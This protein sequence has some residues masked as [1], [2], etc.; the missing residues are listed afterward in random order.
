MSRVAVLI[1]GDYMRFTLHNRLDRFPAL[2]DFRA[3]RSNLMAAYRAAANNVELE[4]PASASADTSCLYRIFY[5]TADPYGGPPFTG[6]AQQSYEF[7]KQ[8]ERE[9]DVAVRRGAVK[10]RGWKVKSSIVHK[11]ING[12]TVQLDKSGIKRNYVQKGVDMRI[13]LDIATLALKRLVNDVVVVT[14]DLDMVPAFKL[15]RTEGLRVYVDT[16]GGM[17]AE[18]KLQVH[19]DRVIG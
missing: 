8:L 17:D 16:M 2:D 12:T 10:F 7:G 11:V 4:N 1:D 14:G 15:A 5:Y 13:G 3:Y 9:E 19:S 6:S 18:A